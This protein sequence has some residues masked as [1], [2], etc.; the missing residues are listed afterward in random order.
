V[1][2]V[3][4]GTSS[5]VAAGYTYKGSIHKGGTKMRI[6][7]RDSRYKLPASHRKIGGH[8]YQYLAVGDEKTANKDADRLRANGYNVRLVSYRGA[9][10]V[11]FR[12]P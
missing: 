11:Y 9:F 2:L 3:V 4:G 12:A 8:I 7:L 5:A 10:A 6:G 1:A